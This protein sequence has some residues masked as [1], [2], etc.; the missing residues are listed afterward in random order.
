MQHI[1]LS[2]RPK[3]TLVT[4][5]E[6]K[7]L[8]KTDILFYNYT[9]HGIRM[10]ASLSIVIKDSVVTMLQSIRTSTCRRSKKI[11][12][13]VEPELHH[14]HHKIKQMEPIPSHFNP[15]PRLSQ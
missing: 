1:R 5:N 11:L 13:L 9:L 15:V 12:P 8:Y 6:E 7:R 10:Y 2:I 14:R 4:F 3:I